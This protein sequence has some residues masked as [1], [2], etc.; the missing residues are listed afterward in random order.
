[1][2]DIGTKMRKNRDYIAEESEKMCEY[3][4]A[5]N[6]LS[7]FDVDKTEQEVMQEMNSCSGRNTPQKLLTFLRS[8]DLNPVS[9]P[10]REGGLTKEKRW[11]RLTGVME[12]NFPTMV[13]LNRAIYAPEEIP[14]KEENKWYKTGYIT[15]Y[16]LVDSIDSE[17]IV[18]FEV[19][20]ER[21]VLEEF[22]LGDGLIKLPKEVFQ[23]AWHS[24][25]LRGYM[26]YIEGKT[27]T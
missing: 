27:K 24:R 18:L 6:F 11:E 26:M 4:C 16:T 19:A 21:D 5:R 2:G 15:H 9:P 8:Y 25:M 7:F 20:G 23:N 14:L 17:N 3:A 10:T 22:N 1:M 13:L 12:R